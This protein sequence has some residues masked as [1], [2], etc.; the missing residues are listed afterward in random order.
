MIFRLVRND[1]LRNKTTTAITVLFVTATALLVTLAV[2]LFV[3]L[4]GAI[5]TLME[6]AKTPHFLQMHSGSLDRS[7]LDSF[8][9]DHPEIV[10][11]Q[12]LEFLN[13]DGA[14]IR[15]GNRSL[16]QSVQ[17]NGFAVQSPR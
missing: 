11:H 14:R 15:V 5:D 8:V 6:D 12:V 10:D 17:D 16:A 4:A 9:D 1:I 2:I 7:R 13:V 3:N